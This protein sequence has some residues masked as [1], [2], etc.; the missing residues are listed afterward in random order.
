[1]T[2]GTVFLE[3]QYDLLTLLAA[4]VAMGSFALVGR[5]DLGVRIPNVL[6][7]VVG[8]LVIDRLFG[9][10]A[11]G[12]L[13]IPT[14]TNPLEFYNLAWTIRYS[15][16]RFSSCLQPF[17]GIGLSEMTKAWI[18]GPSWGFGSDFIRFIHSD[19]IL[20]TGR[21]VGVNFDAPTGVG[22]EATFSLDGRFHRPTGSLE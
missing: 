14:L 15:E 10:L 1:M 2:Q 8:L 22:T 3:E 11:G 19:S 13:P 17:S 18:A 9:V 4:L 20:W 12:E 16:T 21:I 5:D 7:M 6:D